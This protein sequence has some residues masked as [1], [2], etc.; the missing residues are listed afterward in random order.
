MPRADGRANDE[1]RPITITR[2]YLKYAEGS[3]LIEVGDTRVICSASLE[4]RVPHW[5]KGQNTGWLTAEYAMLPRAAEQRSPREL[6]RPSGRTAEIQRLVG[7]A[8]RGAVA[9]EMLGER[10]IF[11]DCDVIQADGG[12]RIA[13]ITGGYIALVDCLRW[14]QERNYFRALPIIEPV[15]AV[16]VGVVQGEDLLDLTYQEDVMAAVDM[17]VIMTASG[18][19][20]EVQGTAEGRPFDRDRLNRLLDLGANGVTQLIEAQMRALGDL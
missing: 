19:F 12:T 15:A 8:L 1:L 18:K 14:M 10:S 7:R 6:S 17:N 5:L 4:D 16:S 20:I 13:S 2:G 11:V 9:L 3:C